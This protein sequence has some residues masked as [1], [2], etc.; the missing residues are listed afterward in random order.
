MTPR[1]LRIDRIAAALTGVLLLAFGLLCLDWR[2]RWVFT[3]YQTSLATGDARA[4]LDTAWFPW[5]F[6]LAGVLLGLLGLVWLLAHLRR[7]G[8][9]TLRLAASDPTGRLEA[10]LTAVA[11]AAAR[12]LGRLA[13][14]TAAAGRTRSYRSHAMVE[15]HGHLDPSADVTTVTD[16]ARACAA[17][18][19]TAFPDDPVSCRIILNAPR[20]RRLRADKRVQVH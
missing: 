19:T 13:P 16:A 14:V 3:D 17:D 4:V 7:A 6:A 12:R 2:Y 15:L 1:L 10:D 8:P 5:V 11:D 9:S 20:Q 18:V